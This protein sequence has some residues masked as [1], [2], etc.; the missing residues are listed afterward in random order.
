MIAELLLR[1]TDD[2]PLNCRELHAIATEI[3]SYINRKVVRENYLFK[4]RIEACTISTA[5]FDWARWVNPDLSTFRIKRELS[6]SRF[7]QPGFCSSR[8][9][10][11]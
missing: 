1:T 6:A 10:W 4:R 11:A 7:L 2:F 9:M 5:P 8:R 3:E